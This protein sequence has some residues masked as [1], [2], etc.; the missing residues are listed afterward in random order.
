MFNVLIVYDIFVFLSFLF[1]ML[2]CLYI[3]FVSVS[4]D[5]Y[6]GGCV[7]MLVCKFVL[8]VVYGYRF[9]SVLKNCCVCMCC[10]CV[11]FCG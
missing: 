11:G 6:F 10:V 2:C 9:F 5:L 7:L 1:M 8:Y 3:Y 4:R